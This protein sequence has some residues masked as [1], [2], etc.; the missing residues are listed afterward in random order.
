[1]DEL[2]LKFYELLSKFVDSAGNNSVD[3]YMELFELKKKIK[4][5]ENTSDEFKMA[6][7]ILRFKMNM[8]MKLALKLEDHTLEENVN[9][10]T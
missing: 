5:K 6:I 4:E 7:K 3:A 10:Y 9:E 2:E 8:A 1:M